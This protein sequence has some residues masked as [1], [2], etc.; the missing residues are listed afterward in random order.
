MSQFIS[1][2]SLIVPDYDQAKEFYVNI[3][4]FE[5]VQDVELAPDKR[6]IVVRPKGAIETCLVFKRAEKTEELNAIGNQA[7][8]GVLLIL[9]TNQFEAD[10]LKM[11]NAGVVF[12][13]APRNEPY[14]K[15][16]IFSDPFG[17]KWDLIQPA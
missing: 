16:V 12:M 4:G 6:W 17:H 9:R 2:I 15:V 11:K 10:Y 3:L 14:G 7:A 13:E 1:S 8:G 5:V